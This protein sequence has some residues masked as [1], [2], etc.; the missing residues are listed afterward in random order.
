ME[1]LSTTSLLRPQSALGSSKSL[2]IF[3]DPPRGL[4]DATRK[5]QQTINSLKALEP[6]V[7]NQQ[8]VALQKQLRQL[9][10]TESQMMKENQSNNQLKSTVVTLQNQLLDGFVPLILLLVTL[11]VFSFP[12]TV[13]KHLTLRLLVLM[14]IH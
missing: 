14:A 2:A 10:E 11:S 9:E 6:L 1:R 7:I 12:E 5:K 13:P 8:R 4:L 3:E